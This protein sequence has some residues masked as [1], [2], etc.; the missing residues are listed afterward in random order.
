M[1]LVSIL[2]QFTYFAVTL[3]IFT[4]SGIP[5][6]FF[7]PGDSLL[8]TAGILADK[9]IF[10]IYI[11][12]V[13]CIIAAILGNMAGYYLGKKWGRGLF[14]RKSNFVFNPRNLK[15][16]E[17]FYNKYGD[18]AI[19]LARFIPIIRTFTPILA[20][21]A[22]MRYSKFLLFT[23]VSAIAWVGILVS[24]GYFLITLVPNIDQYITL[25]VIGIIV[26]SVLPIAYKM[27]KK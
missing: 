2:T 23:I 14:E 1:S 22:N 8:L 10:N 27:I 18:R 5:F 6:G 15:K 9:G 26:L 24:A 3:L 7:F 19:L 13:S 4:E 25:I 12:M 20:G 11:L 16:T 17:D 21:I